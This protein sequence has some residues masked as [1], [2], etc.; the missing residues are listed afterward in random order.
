[1]QK[2]LN[3]RVVKR[4]LFDWASPRWNMII[5]NPAACCIISSCQSP[6][7]SS[8]VSGGALGNNID[9]IITGGAACQVKLLRIFNAARIPIYEGYGPTENSPVI[10]VNCR[11]K[12]APNSGTVGLPDR[13]TGSEAAAWWGDMRERAQCDDGYYKRPDL[14]A[15]TII[16]GWLHTGDIG[17]FEDNRYLKIT[18][19]K[20]N[21]SKRG[22]GKYVAPQAIENKM[23]NPLCGTDHGGRCRSEIHWAHWSYRPCPNLKEWMRLKGISFTTTEDAINNPKVLELYRELVESF[24]TFFN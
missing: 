2:A 9:F 6:I 11:K 14:T 13:R 10:S 4:K 15:E 22:G 24:N 16:D 8:S 21:C 1:M 18:D 3:S 19:R 20:K 23:K 5:S 7:R 12:A 17:V